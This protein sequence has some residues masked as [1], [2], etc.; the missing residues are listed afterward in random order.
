[1]LTERG[2]EIRLPGALPPREVRYEGRTV[3]FV[4]RT[5]ACEAPCWTVEGRTLTT[6]VRLP[7]R[8]AA[9]RVEVEI[10]PAAA[11]PDE[12]RAADGFA[13]RL[14]RLNRAMNTLNG[15]W[16]KGWSPDSLVEAVQTGR[17]VELH[18]EAAGREA[19]A[20]AR[21]LPSIDADIRAMDVDPAAI[22]RALAQ[23]HEDGLPAPPR[24]PVA[25]AQAQV[26]DTER[27]FAKTMADRDHAAFTSFLADETIFF[28][29]K[30]PI[31][32]KQAVA[33]AW[34]S[35]FSGPQAPF[36]WDPDTVEVLDSGA[37]ALSSGPVKDP[38]GKVIGTFNSIWRRE[39]NGSWRV[40]FDKG[41]P[42]CAGQ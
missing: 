5:A 10:A 11:S 6:V 22:A 1:M 40:V 32:G 36:S 17:R 38:Q 31:R 18:P 39:T 8:S 2:Y 4:T 19:L 21:R 25:D 29:A 23:M 35:F 37:L 27:A 33:E 12:R 41:C 20:L 14:A 16:S 30:G 9:E 13:G 24:A 3:A 15:T 28:G 42:V 34:K 7:R 26:R